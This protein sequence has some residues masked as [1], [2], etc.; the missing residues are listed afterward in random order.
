MTAAVNSTKDSRR[1]MTSIT[2]NNLKPSHLAI[3]GDAAYRAGDMGMAKAF[4]QQLINAAPRSPQAH[5][6]MG[7]TLRP[8]R[9]C[10]AMLDVINTLELVT[11]AGVFVGEGIAT[12]MK[13]PAFIDDERFLELASKD[14]EIA[15]VGVTNWHW[16]LQTVLWAAQQVRNLPG[17]FVELG[18]FRGHTTMFLAEYLDFGAWDKRW[19][20]FDTF[21]GIP[22][23]QVDPGWETVNKGAYGGTFT[24]EEVRD[25]FAP[26][27]NID[28]TKGR[29]PEIFETV[30][31]E[32]IAFMHID[33]NNATAEVGALDA[34]Y[35]RISPGGIIVFDDFGWQTAHAQF[36]AESEWFRSRGL[37]VFPVPTGQGVFVKPPQPDSPRA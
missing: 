18:V 8:T 20:L 35:D 28:V 27:G 25:R 3:L 17:D 16:N 24:F 21:E 31:P 30:C 7:L 12:W 10:P 19:W 14:L 22:D 15:P 36:K 33:L 5:S 1:G 2:L 29:V 9:R 23:D 11:R 34:L 37:A 13:Q 4:Y 26:F 32:Q 6:R